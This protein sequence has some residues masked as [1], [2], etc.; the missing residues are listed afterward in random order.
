LQLSGIL[1]PDNKPTPAIDRKIPEDAFAILLGN[2]IAYTKSFPH[3]VIQIK[4]QNLL[5]INKQKDRITI[6]ANFYSRD[7][8]I[9]AG[10]VDNRFDINPNNYYRIERPNYHTLIVYDQEA[11]QM[12]NVEYINPSAIKL[13]G[14]FYIPNRPPVIINENWLEFSGNRFSKFYFGEN[15]VDIHID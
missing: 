10:L 7:G 5:V 11:N 2:T 6:T 13:L 14:K 4:K 8:K 15:K 12:L 9:V 1:I 3:T